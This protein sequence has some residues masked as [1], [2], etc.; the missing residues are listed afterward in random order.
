MCM[1]DGN[2]SPFWICRKWNV[3]QKLSKLHRHCDK[4]GYVKRR[5][6]SN[7][8]PHSSLCHRLIHWQAQCWLQACL[9]WS[10]FD[11]QWIPIRYRRPDGHRSND[12]RYM[13]TSRH[14]HTFRITAPSWGESTGSPVDS[15]HKGPVMWIFD[16]LKTQSSHSDILFRFG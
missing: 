8:Q 15:P 7:I 10:L 5:Y 6:I 1:M 12:W 13:M 11:Q 4:P 9:R 16:C 2:I 3:V 14:G